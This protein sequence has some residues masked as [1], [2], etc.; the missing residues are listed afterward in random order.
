MEGNEGSPSGTS[1]VISRKV[2][3]RGSAHSQRISNAP[4]LARRSPASIKYSSSEKRVRS[5]RATPPAA[6][7]GMEQRLRFP[8]DTNPVAP[9]SRNAS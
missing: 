6:V 1:A 5:D 9:C 4:L 7:L 2:F 3:L 8:R